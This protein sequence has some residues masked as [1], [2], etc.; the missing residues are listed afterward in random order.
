MQE[1]TIPLSLFLDT[2]AQ[3]QV[4]LYEITHWYE[5]ANRWYSEYSIQKNSTQ[6]EFLRTYFTDRR[7]TTL[8]SHA[9]RFISPAV[10]QRLLDI[11]LRS[12]TCRTIA[13]SSA[14]A[15]LPTVTEFLS[16][17]GYVLTGHELYQKIYKR[18]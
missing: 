6:E 12:A 1:G 17:N 3:S 13:L 4:T 14:L 15:E 11:A 9:T 10:L 16:K 7:W 8:P 5:T 2:V 18:P